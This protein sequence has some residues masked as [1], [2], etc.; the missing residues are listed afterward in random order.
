MEFPPDFLGF[1]IETLE[2]WWE[3]R[4]NDGVD[5]GRRVQHRVRHP[6][7][8]TRG[9]NGGRARQRVAAGWVQG[10]GLPRHPAP[11]RSGLL[12]LL[13]D[14]DELDT[15]LRRRHQFPDVQAHAAGR[16]PEAAVRESAFGFPPQL[17]FQ[18]LISKT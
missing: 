1:C 12:R 4:A 16:H 11:D 15:L 3:I 8:G 2:L 10:R 6:P 5:G 13:P 9:G 7:H 17:D 14:A 18:D